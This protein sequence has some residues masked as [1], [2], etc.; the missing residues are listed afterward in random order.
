MK[1]N[2]EKS[3]TRVEAL[4]LMKEHWHFEPGWEIVA[5]ANS[6]GRVTAQTLYAKNTLPV[7]RAS[8]FDGVAVRSADFRNGLPD[9]SRWVKG[10][11]FARADTGDD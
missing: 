10:R 11:D 8:C 6:L 4:T 1:F 5:L 9:T 7:F 2:M 3:V